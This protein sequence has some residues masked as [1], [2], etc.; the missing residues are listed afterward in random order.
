MRKKSIPWCDTFMSDFETITVDTEYYKKHNDTKVYLACSTDFETQTPRLFTDINQWLDF[1]INKKRNQMIFFHNLSWDFSFIIPALQKRG[2]KPIGKSSDKRNKNNVYTTFIN[3]SRVYEIEIFCRDMKKRWKITIRCSLRILTS[4]IK[5]LGEA[6]GIDK[7]HEGDGKEFYNNEPCD[8]VEDYPKRFVEYTVN[9]TLIGLQSLKKFQETLSLLQG[10]KYDNLWRKKN[11]RKPRN[12]LN[13]FTITQITMKLMSMYEILYKLKNKLKPKQKP[14]YLKVDRTTSDFAQ[15]FVQGGLTQFNPQYLGEDVK[16]H[17]AVYIDVNSAYPYQMTQHLPYGKLYD[18]PPS[19]SYYEMHEIEVKKIKIK[20]EYENFVCFKNW[21]KNTDKQVAKTRYVKEL[22]NFKCYYWGFEW[23]TLNKIYDIKVKSIKTKYVKTAPFLNHYANEIYDMRL[24]AK[25]QKRKD[26]VQMLKTLINAG[27]GG[28]LIRLDFPTYLLMD[29]ADVNNILIQANSNPERLFEFGNKQYKYKYVSKIF[30]N[31]YGSQIVVCDEQRKE[32]EWV[33]NRL[34]GS[35]IPA[36][37]RTYL[38]ETILK[39]GVQYFV[40][41]DTD[42]II[43][44]N[45]PDD[46]YNEI[47]NQNS[48]V[49]GAWKLEALPVSISIYGAKR[50]TYKVKDKNGDVKEVNKFAGIDNKCASFDEARK[51]I[52]FNDDEFTIK[53]AVY[54]KVYK[55][56]GIVLVKVDKTFKK[57]GL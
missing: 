31:E 7:N 38:I 25:A 24:N 10:V 37:Q 5:T 27:Y 22:K 36:L 17:N 8:R 34:A 15:L 26:Y 21:L 18:I 13:Y 40:Y 53:D 16:L 35:C 52:S 3:G 11:N 41:C 30:G 43:F 29:N 9:D 23:Q 6:I 39:Y 28:L 42:S 47:I 48:K 57:G 44:N 33:R 20:K 51:L 12:F 4:S 45:L 50:Y 1:H 19:G 46:L 55:P 56:S 32:K 14:F 2:F 49:L 54:R